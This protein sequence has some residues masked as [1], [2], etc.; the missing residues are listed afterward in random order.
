MVMVFKSKD[1]EDIQFPNVREEQWCHFALQLYYLHEPNLLLHS[2]LVFQTQSIP[3]PFSL[4]RNVSSPWHTVYDQQIFVERMNKLVL[5]DAQWSR[6]IR[7]QKEWKQT[8]HIK[9]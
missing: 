4:E 7:A 6:T 1:K 9:Y 8:T 5:L 3:C 2:S